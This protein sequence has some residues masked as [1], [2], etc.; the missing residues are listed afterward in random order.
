MSTVIASPTN[1]VMATLVI[2]G[3]ELW[4]TAPKHDNPRIE[5][6]RRRFMVV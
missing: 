5:A 1:D 4:A 3:P 6:A 2:G